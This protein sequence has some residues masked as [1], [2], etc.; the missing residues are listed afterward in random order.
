[1]SNN[2]LNPVQGANPCARLGALY[3]QLD[4]A[5]AGKSTAEV[6]EGNSWIKFHLPNVNVLRAEIRRLERLCGPRRDRFA[7]RVGPIANPWGVAIDVV[8]W[9]YYPYSY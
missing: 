1:M 5:M 6:R 8:R 2:D 4:M 7:T 9:P 3:Q